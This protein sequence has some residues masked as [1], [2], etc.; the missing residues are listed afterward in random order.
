MSIQISISSKKYEGFDDCLAAAAKEYAEDHDL[1]GYE[2]EARWADENT[3]RDTIVL[4]VPTASVVDRCDVLDYDTA[5]R[6]DGS[7]SEELVEQSV[8]AEPTGA[9]A[10]YRDDDGSWQYVPDCDV[11]RMRRLGCDVQTVYVELP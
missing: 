10:A 7:A 5:D 4:T 6:L 2:V 8:A 9:V 11:E 3:D 1:P